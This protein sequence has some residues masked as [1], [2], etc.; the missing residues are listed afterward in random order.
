VAQCASKTTGFYGLRKNSSGREV[1][2]LTTSDQCNRINAGFGPW[3]MLLGIF[4]WVL[5]FPAVCLSL[6]DALRAFLF[7]SQF[8]FL[9]KSKIMYHFCTVSKRDRNSTKVFNS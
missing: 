1:V 6:K 7:D 8:G 4:A 9:E 2:V 3:G 5:P